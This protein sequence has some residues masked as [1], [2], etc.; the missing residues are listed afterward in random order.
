M[1]KAVHEFEGRPYRPK[2]LMDPQDVI[3]M[4]LSVLTLPERSEVT[5]LHIRPAKRLPLP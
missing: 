4:V 5:E 3:D 2:L 1:Q